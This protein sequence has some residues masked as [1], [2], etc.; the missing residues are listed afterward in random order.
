MSQFLQK[1]HCILSRI[2]SKTGITNKIQIVPPMHIFK[3]FT[4]RSQISLNKSTK[5]FFKLLVFSAYATAIPG[6]ENTKQCIEF[7]C[8]Y[9]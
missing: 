8:K 5:F 1:L 9:C 6:Y 2:D 3:I 7:I 4:Y